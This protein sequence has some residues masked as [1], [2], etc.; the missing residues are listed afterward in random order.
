M[1]CLKTASF[2]S[3]RS[4]LSFSIAQR[5]LTGQSVCC[6]AVRERFTA[7]V[8]DAEQYSSEFNKDTRSGKL[9]AMATHGRYPR[10][11]LARV[12]LAVL[13]CQRAMNGRIE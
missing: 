7:G 4:R 2:Y 1:V 8:S 6:T 3:W 9:Q 11:G 13:F 12:G 10:V 5:N